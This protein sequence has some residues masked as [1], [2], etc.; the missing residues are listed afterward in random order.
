[1]EGNAGVIRS[2]EFVD[3]CC[4]RLEEEQGRRVDFAR[5]SLGLFFTRE[6]SLRVMRF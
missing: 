1:M 4:E 5:S 6:L 2:V 3:G